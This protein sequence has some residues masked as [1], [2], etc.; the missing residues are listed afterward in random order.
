MPMT[1]LGWD[2]SL[3]R[4]MNC[5][6]KFSFTPGFFQSLSRLRCGNDVH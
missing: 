6:E 4:N 1:A 5:V 2:N 3:R